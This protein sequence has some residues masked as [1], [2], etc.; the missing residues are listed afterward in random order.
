MIRNKKGN[1]MGI[2]YVVGA[3]FL[4][5]FLGLL[6]VFGGM[7]LN[8]VFDVATPELTGIGMVGNSNMTQIGSLTLNPVN[9]VVQ[10][11][12]WL[13][14]VVYVFA[15]VAC[16]G[17]A[18]AFRFSG[19]KWLVGFFFSA[20]LMLLIGSIF[21]SNIYEEFY[22]DTGD[23][24][25]RLHEFGLLSFLILYSPLVIS[26][27]GFVCGIIMFTGDGGEQSTA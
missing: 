18:F 7:T 6:M 23:V 21:I 25:L 8:W 10:S 15:L 14:G 17:L 5:M 3:L 27:I 13:T 12:T 2:I 4:L 20:M 19:N 16:L 26:V 22:N 9:N 1:I 11:F 24:G